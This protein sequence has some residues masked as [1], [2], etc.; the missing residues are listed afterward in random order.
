M[1]N[2]VR[3]IN[4]DGVSEDMFKY[5]VVLSGTLRLSRGPSTSKKQLIVGHHRSLMLLTD[6]EYLQWVV[7]LHILFYYKHRRCLKVPTEVGFETFLSRPE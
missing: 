4:T 7:A 6:N 1:R 5:V 3:Q 2:I